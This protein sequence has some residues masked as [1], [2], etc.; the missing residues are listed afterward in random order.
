MKPTSPQKCATVGEAVS[1]YFPKGLTTLFVLVLLSGCGGG[2]ASS[3]GGLTGN[4]NVTLLMTGSAND[5]FTSF[6]AGITSLTLTSKTGATVNLLRSQIAADF[7]HQDGIV[8]PEVT[9]SVPQ[10]TYVSATA[11]FNGGGFVCDYLDPSGGVTEDIY[12]YEVPEPNLAVTLPAPITV[13][14]GSMGLLLDLQVS[15]SISLTGCPTSSDESYTFQPV[16]ELTPVAL[17]AQPTNS[18]NGMALNRQGMI[19]SIDSDGGGFTITGIYD[20]SS[21][22]VETN[23]TTVYLGVTGFS[24]LAV[25]MP[26]EIDEAIQSDGSLAATRVQVYD[27]NTN[28][29]SVNIVRLLNTNYTLE[30]PGTNEVPNL[31][32]VARGAVQGTTVPAID[33]C[34]VPSW[35]DSNAVFQVSGQLTNLQS[36]P[37]SARFDASSMAP[38]QL[39]AATTHDSA[40]VCDTVN[41]YNSATTITLVPQ[42]IDG[43]V[44]AVSSEGSFTTYSVALASYDYFTEFGSQ[45]NQVLPVA[46]PYTV[47]VYAD[48]NTQQLNATPVAVGGVFRFYGLVFNDNGTLRMDCAQV[49][50]GVA[51]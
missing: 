36:L 41:G 7:I 29:L 33:I 11:S 30:Y 35:N 1:S 45:P 21:P 10:G 51:E 8:E 17:A 39:I 43:T 20:L 13:S 12:D 28:T 24:Q 18:A 48:S 37:F 27:T 4:T 22:H 2:T 25:G 5:V 14:G 50:D 32:M 47:V 46:D 42:T 6:L 44:E 23:Q 40:H 31:L 34:Q 26:V 49:N 19:A 9:V 3:G 16:L 38:G 15:K